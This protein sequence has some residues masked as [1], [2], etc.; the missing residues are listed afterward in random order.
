MGAP[1]SHTPTSIARSFASVYYRVAETLPARLPELYGPSSALQHAAISAEGPAIADLCTHLPLAGSRVSVTSISAQETSTAALLVQVVGTFAAPAKKPAAFTQVF[2]LERQLG[3]HEDHFFCRNDLFTTIDTPVGLV[4]DGDVGLPAPRMAP[5]S[6]A[7]SEEPDEDDVS[8]DASAP[9]PAP[10]P[11]S[12]VPKDRDVDMTESTSIAAD[13]PMPPPAPASSTP[14]PVS[15]V[16][17]PR[18]DAPPPS[19]PP[20]AAPSTPVSPPPAAPAAPPK[21]TW[22]SIVSA[23]EPAP[24]PVAEVAS[25]DSTA[26]EHTEAKTVA[27]SAAVPPTA[28]SA[29]LSS[30]KPIDVL[31]NGYAHGHPSHHNNHASGAGAPGEHQHYHKPGG[32]VFGPSAVVQL[33]ALPADRLKDVKGLVSCFR[34]EFAGYGHRLRHVEVKI[35][36]G[37]AFIEYDAADGVHAAVAAWAAGPRSE[38]KFAGIPLSVTEKRVSYNNRRPGSMRGGRGGMRGGR[39]GRPVT[40]PVS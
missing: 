38:G 15:V 22:A 37:L 21:K 30:T 10:E 39:R 6:L 17:A 28:A 9:S 3:S 29:A 1:A 32:R 26:P 16:P 27:A 31:Q 34:E 8:E 25:I 20:P 24:A 12:P 14:D 19:S 11:M 2:V 35:A 7:A 13:D 40:S 4:P 18:V 5:A 33:S 23:T 36:K